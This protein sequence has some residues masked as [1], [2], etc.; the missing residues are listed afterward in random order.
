[1]NLRRFHYAS[2]DSTSERAFAAL[3]MGKA[4]HGDV[5]VA[6]A[7]TAGHGRF[8]RPWH[9]PADEGLYLSVILLPPAP[10]WHPGAVT[11]AASLAVHDA[12]TELGL[13][14]AWIDWPNDVMVGDAKLA[15]V[16]VETRGLDPKHPHFV[17]GLG[18]NVRQRAFPPELAAARGVTSLALQGLDRDV[19]SVERKVLECLSRRVEQIDSTP[20]ELE[21][22]FVHA[23]GLANRDVRVRVG[24]TEEL[25]RFAGFSFTAGLLLHFAGGREKR[26]PIEFVRAVERL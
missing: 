19:P 15:G 17:V 4:R 20:A 2:T 26:L 6:D 5:H 16:L 11:V 3:A 10:P 8:G 1:M 24:E 23:T 22:D 21:V 9:S 18:V 7:Q 12:A 25:G 13:R 14:G